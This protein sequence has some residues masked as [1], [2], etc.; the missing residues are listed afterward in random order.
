MASMTAP[1]T[2]SSGLCDGDAHA[3]LAVN[4]VEGCAGGGFVRSLIR[5]VE[6]ANEADERGNVALMGV[7]DDDVGHGSLHRWNG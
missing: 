4:G 5:R 7:A 1:T 3:R 2:V 6:L